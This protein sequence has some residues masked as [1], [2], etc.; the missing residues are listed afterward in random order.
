[1]S[2]VVERTLGVL[3]ALLGQHEPGAGPGGA[4]G[5]HRLSASSR[6]GSLIR[7]ITALTSKHVRVAG[8][9]PG[10][11]GPLSSSRGLRAGPLSLS[12]SPK[13]RGPLR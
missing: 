5:P 2:D 11:A 9:A 13:R 10:R 8:G 4:G 12:E 3:P 6:L 1:M 7:N